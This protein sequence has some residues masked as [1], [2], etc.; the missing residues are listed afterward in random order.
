MKTLIA[1]EFKK[2]FSRRITQISLA[3][4]LLLSIIFAVSTCRGMYAYDGVSRQGSG[5]DAIALDKEI[6]AKYEGALTDEKVQQMLEDFKSTGDLHGL[7][8]KYVYQNSL[9]SSVHSRFSDENGNWN[10]LSVADVYGNEE[11]QVGYVNGWLNV[12]QY[13]VRLF[14]IMAALIILMLAP[15]F[16]GEYAGVDSLILA[17]KYGKT[18]SGTAK[19]IA[20]LLAALSVTAFFVILNLAAA[21]AIYG[22][23][24]LDSSI[25]FAPLQFTEGYIPFNITCKTLIAYQVL[26]VFTGSVCLTGITVFLSS[27]CKNQF[28]A[29]VA[30]AAV[31][32]LPSL[33]LSIVSSDQLVRLFSLT[34]IYQ[35]QFTELMSVQKMSGGGLYAVWAV[36]LAAVLFTL[37]NI[38]S[39]RVF[40]RHQVS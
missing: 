21:F 18:K 30:S 11:I 12:S 22:G 26:L 19:S 7:N 31:F 35:L 1:F 10:G 38:M 15:V 25:L 34:P 17:A 32:A 5:A 24:G 36:P 40:S 3:A 20:A 8:V 28:V 23:E 29:L 14:L 4:M 9:Q 39:R 33:L 2:I 37:G 27:V 13:M 16:C 6:C